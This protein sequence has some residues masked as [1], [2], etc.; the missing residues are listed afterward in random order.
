MSLLRNLAGVCL[1]AL[2]LNGV[3]GE[4]VDINSANADTL[5][6]GITGIGPSR[7]KAIVLYREQHGPFKSVDDLVLIKG[8]GVSIVDRNRDRLAA[9]NTSK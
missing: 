5:A 8:I 6:E 1:L 9:S 4:L 2:A 3:C 7:A